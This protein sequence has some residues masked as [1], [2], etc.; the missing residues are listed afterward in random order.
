MVVRAV[1]V[2]CPNC[3]ANLEIAS[4][5]IQASCQYCGTVSRIQARTAMFQIPKAP[6]M[7]VQPA[8][9]TNAGWSH[10]VMNFATVVAV[11]RKGGFD[12]AVIYDSPGNDRA[13]AAGGWARSCAGG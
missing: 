11:S 1:I 6:Q 12:D 3:N 10:L 4:T 9:M 7:P 13:S 2:R 5:V 8:T